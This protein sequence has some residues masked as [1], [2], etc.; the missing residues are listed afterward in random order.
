MDVARFISLLATRSLYF[1]CPP[2]EFDD[3]YEGLLPR[4]HYEAMSKMLRERFVEPLLSLRKD[5]AA[6]G[7]RGRPIEDSLDKLRGQ[8]RD[9]PKEATSKFGVCCW[10]ESEGESDAMWKLYSVSGQSIAIESTIGQLRA[11]LGDREGVIIDRV[12]YADFDHDPIE[13]GHKHYGLFLKRK[14]FEFEKEVRATVLLPVPGKGVP[15]GCDLDILITCIHL[16]PLA[17]EFVKDAVEALCAGNI[18]G[19]RKPVRQSL[20]YREPSYGIEVEPN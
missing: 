2:T 13:K 9:A 12:R 10:H 3:P 7:I 19:L 17:E 11:S 20:L 16:S 15:V 6:K 5:F 8:W 14:C 4:S 1:A 18:V